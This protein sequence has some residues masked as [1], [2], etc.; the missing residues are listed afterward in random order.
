MG[1]EGIRIKTSTN[2]ANLCHVHLRVVEIE[3]I[4]TTP[5]EVTIAACHVPITTCYE[6][7]TV[8]GDRYLLRAARNS[9]NDATFSRTDVVVV[10]PDAEGD[11]E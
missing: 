8:R 7:Q 6:G 3:H 10:D 4:Y 1:N 5:Q 2:D 9:R 11:E